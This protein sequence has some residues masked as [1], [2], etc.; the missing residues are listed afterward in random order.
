MRVLVACEFSG[1]VRRAFRA[2]GHEAYSC[3]LRP[4][5][6][7]SMYHYVGDALPILHY[8]WDLLIAHPPCTYLARCGWHWVNKPDSP[9]GVYPLKGGPRRRAA[10]E[11]AQ[12]FR[13]FLDAPIQRKAIENPRP[14][15]HAGLPPASQTIQPWQFGHPETKATCLWLENLPPL[16]PTK[17]VEGREARI[18]KM[19]PGRDREKERSRTYGGIAEAMAQQ[20]GCL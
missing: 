5:E 13:A 3:D 2:L 14:I 1:V 11:A 20:W 15:V 4:A 10:T 19:P 17:I 6:D 8:G 18:W 16:K 9:P 7:Q 12:F